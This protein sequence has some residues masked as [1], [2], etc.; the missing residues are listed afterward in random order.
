MAG[1]LVVLICA[2]AESFL[3]YALFRFTREL[4]RRH[5]THAVSA[6]IPVTTPVSGKAAEDRHHR[7]VIDITSRKPAVVSE[8]GSEQ[9]FLIAGKGTKCK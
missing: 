9:G 2:V 4:R 1:I 8:S 7:K 5:L 3:I 6:A